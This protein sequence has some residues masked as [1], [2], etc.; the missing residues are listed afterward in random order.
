[1][2]TLM[3]FASIIIVVTGTFCLANATAA[4]TAVAFVVGVALVFLGAMELLV[5]RATVMRAGENINEINA[6]GLT[7]GILGVVILAGQISEEVT[8]TAIFALWLVM[9]G[10]RSLSSVRRD[11][12]TNSREDNLLFLLGSAM[13]LCGL[14]MF[15]NKA[16]LDIRV[17]G[18]IGIAMILIGLSRFKVALAIEYRKPEFLT[19]NQEKLDEA[20]RAEK[21]AMKKAKE[22]IR[23]TREIQKRISRLTREIAKEQSLKEG[24]ELRRR[25][26]KN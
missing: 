9:D 22:G 8:V 16:L 1:M 18:L 11:V 24:S 23:E 21:R 20:K 19:G 15:F 3:M 26:K 10:L 13:T 7:A 4:F 25:A 14:Y 5:S 2:R 12:R 6:E 17:M